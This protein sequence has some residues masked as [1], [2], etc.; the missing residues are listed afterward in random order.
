[1]LCP[2]AVVSGGGTGP[3]VDVPPGRWGPPETPH[4]CPAQGTARAP[5]ESRLPGRPAGSSGRERAV[6]RAGA[7]PGREAGMGWNS[8]RKQHEREAEKLLFPQQLMS[9]D[10]C[11]GAG[12]RGRGPLLQG[13]PEGWVSP[14]SQ[15]QGLSELALTT[16]RAAVVSFTASLRCRPWGCSP[17]QVSCL[18]LRTSESGRG[19]EAGLSGRSHLRVT[20]RQAFTGP[21]LQR[22]PFFKAAFVSLGSETQERSFPAHP[23]VWVPCFQCRAPGFPRQC[24]QK[25]KVRVVRISQFA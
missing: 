20:P 11:T 8:F 1:M 23:V 12:T 7:W 24:G 17:S 21:A 4:I 25:I 3:S 13:P 19:G 16:S 14:E 6:L 2:E 22:P 10:W 18:C 9:H 5:Q 15:A